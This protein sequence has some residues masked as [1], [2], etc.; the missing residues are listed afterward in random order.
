MSDNLEAEGH[1]AHV[2]DLAGWHGGL[3][4]EQNEIRRDRSGGSEDGEV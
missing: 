3:A 1:D 2:V 4:G